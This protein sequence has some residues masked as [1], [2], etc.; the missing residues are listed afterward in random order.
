MSLKNSYTF[1]DISTWLY[2]L[3][4]SWRGGG[5]STHLY[6]RSLCRGLYAKR[7]FPT[8]CH[9]PLSVS[10]SRPSSSLQQQNTFPFYDLFPPRKLET[11]LRHAC[12]VRG[13]FSLP[14]TN[15]ITSES[16]VSNCAH[17]TPDIGSRVLEGGRQHRGMCG[18]NSFLVFFGK[19]L[20][21][22]VQCILRNSRS[23]TSS[24]GQAEKQ[25]V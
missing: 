22:N 11:D 23:Q 21:Q 18:G 2:S 8:C 13:I 24:A 9:L 7:A 20:R 25:Q 14:L 4:I 5:L 10:I 6:H 1:S 19:N 15:L 12:C 3:Y 17:G 16:H